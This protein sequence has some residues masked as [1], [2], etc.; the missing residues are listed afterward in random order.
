[1]PADYLPVICHLSFAG[2]GDG[3]TT[4][5]GLTTPT[6][7]CTCTAARRGIAVFVT[8][9]DAAL[10]QVVDRQF[11]GDAISRQNANVVLANTTRRVAAYRGAIVEGDTKPAIGEDFLYQTVYFDKFF[12]C[13]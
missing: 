1:M 7:R 6:Y 13:H 11:Q 8:E 3:V 4:I 2:T 12:F 10:G 5:I 9:I